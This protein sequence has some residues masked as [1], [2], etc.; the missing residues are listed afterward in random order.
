MRKHFLILLTILSSLK[1]DAQPINFNPRGIGGGGALFFPSI[2]PANDNEFYVSCDMSQL[3][4]SINFG[5]NYD[6]IPFTKLQVFNNSTYEFTIDPNI[7]YCNYNDGN[8]GYPVKTTDGGNTW[9]QLNGYDLNN[10]GTV[11]KI[12]SNYNINPVFP[13]KF[14]R[15]QLAE[16][17]HGA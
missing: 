12:H 9:N 7:A 13:K 10:Y 8:N 1:L 11:Y 14:S 15:F 16:E 3:F 6:Q 2:N 4:H 17:A 5:D